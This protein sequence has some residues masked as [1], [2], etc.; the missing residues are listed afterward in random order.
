[1]QPRPE[2]GPAGWRNA[3]EE[4]ESERGLKNRIEA[5][6]DYKEG[7]RV[8]ENERQHGLTPISF[9]LRMIQHSAQSIPHLMPACNAKSLS[10]MI[11]QEPFR[12]VLLNQYYQRQHGTEKTTPF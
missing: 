10:L 8:L 9:V 6:G 7:L 4:R 1:M 2:K 5:M 3:V 12:L 11:L